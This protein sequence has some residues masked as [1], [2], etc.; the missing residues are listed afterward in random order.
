M[1]RG[2]WQAIVHRV[3]QSWTQLKPLSMHTQ[4]QMHC[5]IFASHWPCCLSTLTR[6]CGRRNTL[7]LLL[8]SFMAADGRQHVACGVKGQTFIR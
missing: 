2:I 7:H 6:D 4:S 3:A 1:D 5:G 8:S